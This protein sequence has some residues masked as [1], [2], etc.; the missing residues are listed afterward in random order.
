[1]ISLNKPLNDLRGKTICGIYKI[2]INNKTY[3]GSSLDIKKRL[4][5]HRREL[6]KNIHDNRYL[7]NLYNKYN[8]ATYEILE[9]CSISISNIDLRIK[10]QE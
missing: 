4:R 2:V 1:M 7:Q 3:V 8:N 5:Q 10:E 9:K 6:R